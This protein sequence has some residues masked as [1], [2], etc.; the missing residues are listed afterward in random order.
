M[1]PLVRCSQNRPV[2]DNGLS[3]SAGSVVATTTTTPI[4]RRTSEAL[5][6]ADE[7]V[8]ASRLL[9]NM[10]VQILSIICKR[11]LCTF[12]SAVCFTVTG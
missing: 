9:F 1:V 8:R 6:E 11:V 2:Q 10:P 3:S 4:T 12:T 5:H 7:N